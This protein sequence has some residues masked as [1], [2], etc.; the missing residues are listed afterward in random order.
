MS[1]ETMK[2]V[3]G[4]CRKYRINVLQLTLKEVENSEEVKTLSAF[5]HGRS[6]NLKHLIK[7]IVKCETTEQKRAFLQGLIN[8]LEG[9]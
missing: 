9:K 3:G 4:Y 8:I 2:K 1:G 7:Y 5:E 6:T